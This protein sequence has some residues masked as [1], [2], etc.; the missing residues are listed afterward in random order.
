MK[1]QNDSRLNRSKNIDLTEQ[2]DTINLQSSI[3]NLQFG[4]SS[5]SKNL[6]IPEAVMFL[7]GESVT[8]FFIGE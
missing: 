3:F 1:R 4:L 2:G 8:I 6:I 5:F 7:K